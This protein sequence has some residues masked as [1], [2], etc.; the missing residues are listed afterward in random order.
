MQSAGP[1]V[2]L[3]LRRMG[4]ARLHL[5]TWRRHS[6]VVLRALSAQAHA[7]ASAPNARRPP[8]FSKRRSRRSVNREQ[9]DSQQ[10]HFP[11]RPRHPS[12][13][14]GVPSRKIRISA[15]HKIWVC[16]CALM[17]LGGYDGHEGS[18]A[19]SMSPLFSAPTRCDAENYRSLVQPD[20]CAGIM[21][22]EIGPETFTKVPLADRSDV[23][24]TVGRSLN[25]PHLPV[26]TPGLF[27]SPLHT[28]DS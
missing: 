17:R 5:S 7:K 2:H 10:L 1:Y 13:E 20:M 21:S 27:A 22:I 28:Q 8:I 3:P 12:L 25:L 16:M 19:L 26:L 18:S 23:F 24:S 9:S 14:P 15:P 6:L 11:I 4:W